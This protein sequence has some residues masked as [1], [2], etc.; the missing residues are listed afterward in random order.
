MEDVYFMI[1]FI[2][3]YYSIVN[4]FKKNMPIVTVRH[5]ATSIVYIAC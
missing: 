2:D 1:L 3:F 4:K 5:N